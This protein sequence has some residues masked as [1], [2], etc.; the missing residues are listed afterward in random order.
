[1]SEIYTAMTAIMEEIP[2]IGK[3]KKNQQQD[4]S[5]RGID[6]VYNA[7]NGIMA[8]HGVFVCPEVLDKSREERTNKNGTVLAF[9]TLTVKYTFYAKDGS[10]VS[11]VVCGEGMDSGDKATSK[12]LSISQKYA[13]FQVFTIPTQEV[14]DPDADSYEVRAKGAHP[15]DDEKI[16]KAF[17]ASIYGALPY[18]T[19]DR[20][21]LL[22]VIGLFVGRPLASSK[23][24]TEDE[25]KLITKKPAGL[26]EYA[27][28][29]AEWNMG[30]N[31]K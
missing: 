2:A 19:N 26:L 6:D 20:D 21:G 25:I 29:E 12:A 9:V 14:V 28:T 23:D 31:D 11:C 16:R 18:M 10:S 4:F 22:Q 13:F 27:P 1:M 24:L 7:V 3:N 5:Y 8:K 30:K 15:L 17:F